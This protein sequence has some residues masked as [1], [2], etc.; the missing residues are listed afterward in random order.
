MSAPF[1]GNENTGMPEGAGSGNEGQQ[2]GNPAW[3]EFLSVVPQELHEKVT[4]IL[5]KWDQ[6]VQQ[7]FEKVQSEYK[8]WK[9]FI[10]A[11]VDAET[12]TFA[13]NLFNRLQEDPKY[14]WESLGQHYKFNQAAAQQSG[15]GQGS[16]EVQEEDPYHP[17]IAELERQQQLLTQAV[18]K[19]R[20]AAMERQ[21][22]AQLDAEL[23]SAKQKFGSFNER[24]VLGLLQTGM[25]VDEAVQNYRDTI[26]Q[27]VR[28]YRPKPLIMGG[29]GSIP[30]NGIDPSKLDDAGRRNLVVQMLKAHASE[31]NQ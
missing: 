17:R 13:L 10:D 20:E 14:V 1:G 12:A 19:E 18:L 5:Q 8:P 26:E 30:G 16:N 29:G 23:A 21:A 24:Y 27:E 11:G 28:S 15:Q 6:G 4:P 3:G 31:R 22:E 2:Q 9:Q 25:S 7:R